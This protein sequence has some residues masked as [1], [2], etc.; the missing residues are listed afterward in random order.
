MGIIGFTHILFLTYLRN[1]TVSYAR[2]YIFHSLIKLLPERQ[3][4]FITLSHT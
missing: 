1:Y 2:S 3:R 4:L